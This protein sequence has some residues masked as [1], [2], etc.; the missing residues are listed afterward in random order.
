METLTGNGFVSTP[1][2]TT[3]GI[4]GATGGGCTCGVSNIGCP[5]HGRQTWTPP[6]EK[7]HFCPSD[8]KKLETDWAYCPSCGRPVGTLQTTWPSMILYGCAANQ[9]AD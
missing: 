3:G 2:G 7:W 1:Y 8:G 4:P 9:G 5:V 6:F